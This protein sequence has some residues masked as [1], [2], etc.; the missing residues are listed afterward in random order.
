[1]S[2]PTLNELIEKRAE[3]KKEMDVRNAE[4]K[5]LRAIQDDLDFQLIKRLDADG[6]AR[7]A[8]KLASVSIAETEVPESE[9]W[10]A[11]YSHIM[12]TGDFSILQKRM[13]STACREMWKLGETIPGVQ[14]RTV[15]RINFR[16]L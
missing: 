3:I 2:I 1:M 10:D 6:V 14:P 9:D 7:T 16:S 15:R 11:V 12:E 4:L 8:N 5:D 13:S